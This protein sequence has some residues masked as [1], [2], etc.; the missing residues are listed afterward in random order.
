MQI[1]YNTI[2]GLLSS[3]LVDVF[4][5]TIRVLLLVTTARWRSNIFFKIQTRLVGSLNFYFYTLNWARRGPIFNQQLSSGYHRKMSPI[6]FLSNWWDFWIP[7]R[8]K[9]KHNNLKIILPVWLKQTPNRQKT[10]CSIWLKTEIIS[11]S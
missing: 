3:D 7:F 8:L 11:K 1:P 2:C 6:Y 10:K 9:Q 4:C 5:F